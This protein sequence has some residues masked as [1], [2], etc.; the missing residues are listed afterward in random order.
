MSVALLPQSD[1]SGRSLPNAQTLV[2][3]A[4]GFIGGRLL[5][6]G[7]IPMYRQLRPG[8]MRQADLLDPASLCRACEGMQAV[9]HCAGYA[10]AFLDSSAELHH[11]VNYQGT[12]NLLKAAGQAGVKTFIYLSSIKAMGE[13]GPVCVDED[14]S[15]PPDTPYGIA[16]RAAEDAVLEAGVLHGMHVVNLRLAMVYGRGGGGNLLRMANGIR[17]GWFPPLPETGNRRSLVHVDDVI[18]AIE[19]VA[20]HHA[21]NGRTYIVAHPEGVSGATLYRLL[22]ATLGLRPFNWE[23]PA[24]GLRFAAQLCDLLAQPLGR[25]LPLSRAAISAL[26]DSAFYSPARL[27]ADLGWCAKVDL[28]AGLQEMFGE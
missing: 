21:A 4:S 15:T 5:K 7:R 19:C 25:T 13:P 10:H 23:L 18:R 16:K 28:P 3:G 14:F 11:A 2:T 20:L 1:L 26:L 6:A 22:R 12:V 17:K 9:F 27:T 8:V 24:F